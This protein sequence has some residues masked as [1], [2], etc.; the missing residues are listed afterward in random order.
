MWRIVSI[1]LFLGMAAFASTLPQTM[2]EM[3]HEQEDEI[4]A[5]HRDPS[6]PVPHH[7]TDDDDCAICR[8]IHMPMASFSAHVWL[9][10]AGEWVR[11]VSMLA[12]SQQSQTFPTRISCRGPPRIPAC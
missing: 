1:L 6:Q 4:Q 12:A 5:Q 7:H 3:Q 10:N 2:H 8:Q 9:I 11:F